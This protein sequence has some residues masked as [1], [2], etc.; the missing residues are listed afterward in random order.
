MNGVTVDIRG[1]AELQRSLEKLGGAEAN[2][3]LQ[4]ATAAAARSLK[5]DVVSEMPKPRLPGDG[6]S[7]PGALKRSATAKR[8]RRDRPASI[9]T[10]RRSVAYWWPMVL[11]GSRPHRIR[12]PGQVAAGVQRS[13]LKGGTRGGGNIRHPGHKGNDFLSRGLAKGQDKA[14][15]AASAVLDKYLASI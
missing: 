14:M 12:F 5:R 15:A 13:N 11:G 8:A 3:M 6:R 4:K 2:A 10:N 9:V 7:Y 1:A